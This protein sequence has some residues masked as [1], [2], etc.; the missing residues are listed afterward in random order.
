MEKLWSPW[1]SQYIESFKEEKEVEC[2][3]CEASKK[4][5]NDEKYLL[6][7]KGKECFVILNKFPYNS[8]HMMIVPYRHLSDMTE[9]TEKELSEMMRFVQ[10]AIKAL[11]KVMKPQGYNFGANL[12]KPAGAGIDA[13]VHFHILPRW[14]GDTNFMP[15]IGEVKVISQ[16][17][18]A[19]RKNI[20]KAF[21]EIISG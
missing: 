10:I 13:H 5:V 1:R 8:G 2:I 6:V 21:L 4:D 20:A 9:L 18:L 15:V 17:L 12:G 16:D 19:T 11:E 3:F 14:T 7:Y